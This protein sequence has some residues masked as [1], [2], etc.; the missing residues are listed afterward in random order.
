M[1][2]V[3]AVDGVVVASAEVEVVVEVV[4]IV[5]MTGTVGDAV[6]VALAI[7]PADTATAAAIP[8]VR[9]AA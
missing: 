6:V 3:D 2:G 9:A 1:V 4:V 7:P 8:A 5:E